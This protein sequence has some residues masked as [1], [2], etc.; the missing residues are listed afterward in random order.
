M[1]NPKLHIT[2]VSRLSLLS[3]NGQ[4][5]GGDFPMFYLTGIRKSVYQEVNYCETCQDTNKLNKK[6]GKLPAEEAEYIPRNKIRVNMIVT[7]FIRR[8]EDRQHLNLKTV[9]IL[10]KIKGWFEIT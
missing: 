9:T 10:D 1:N 8:K 4:N 3:K 5:V 7:Y 6:Y 2:L